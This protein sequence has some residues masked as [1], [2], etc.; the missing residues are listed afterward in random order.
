MSSLFDAPF[1]D[2]DPPPEDPPPAAARIERK[3]YSVSE[4]TSA[5]RGVLE[6]SFDEV[7]VEGEISNCKAYNGHLYFTLKDRAC[8][9]RSFMQDRDEVF[10]TF[11]GQAGFQV[12]AQDIISVATTAR[13]LRLIKPTTHSYFEVLRTKLKWGER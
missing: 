2:D 3:I 5:I 8:Q 9:I 4:L 1:E 7:W 13:P 12:E 10:V 11:D 6:T